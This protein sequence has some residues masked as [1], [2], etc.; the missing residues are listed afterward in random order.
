M[1]T[2]KSKAHSK[3]TFHKQRALIRI[4]NSLIA[5]LD[6]K[7]PYNIFDLTG[8]KAEWDVDEVGT[9]KGSTVIAHELFSGIAKVPF[10][11]FHFFEQFAPHFDS[12]EEHFD[13]IADDCVKLYCSDNRR[14]I[15]LLERHH[16]GEHGVI[17]YDDEGAPAY[18]FPIALSK[19]AP[20]MD[21]L[22]HVGASFTKRCIAK[23]ENGQKVK[24]ELLTPLDVCVA[25]LNR[26]HTFISQCREKQQWCFV[27]STDND[28]YVPSSN[29]LNIKSKD[30]SVLFNYLCNTKTEY[31]EEE[32]IQDVKKQVDNPAM[33]ATLR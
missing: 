26:K 27:Y 21:I 17:Y 25:Q 22:M 16:S 2:L 32:T 19:A 18:N 12:I 31:V 9:C 6:P 28:N 10:A 5:Q 33:W 14:A 24:P 3:Y 4:Y 7:K 11:E 8:G 15:K 20:K 1:N 23:H 30:G 29:L 13:K